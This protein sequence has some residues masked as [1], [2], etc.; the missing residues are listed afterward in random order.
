MPGA[1]AADAHRAAAGWSMA[2]TAVVRLRD[3]LGWEQ[4]ACLAQM[5]GPTA[6][7]PADERLLRWRPVGVDRRRPGEI[8]GIGI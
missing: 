1:Q 3:M 8:E 2:G 4:D 6:G 7:Q 5:T